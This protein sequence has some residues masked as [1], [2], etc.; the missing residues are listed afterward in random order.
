MSKP[1]D[2]RILKSLREAREYTQDEVAKRAGISKDSLSRIERG[3]QS[4]T[5]QHTIRSLAK[6]FG[7]TPE[8]LTGE[9]NIEE[10]E[11]TSSPRNLL[12]MRIDTSADNALTLV[13]RR[14]GF[15]RDRIVELAPLLFVIAAERSLER[16]RNHVTAVREALN[17]AAAA[18]KTAGCLGEAIASDSDETSAAIAAIDAE[19]ESIANQDII[20]YDMFSEGPFYSDP[21]KENPFTSSL[22]EDATDPDLVVVV[23]IVPDFAIFRV[24]RADAERLADGDESL[25][26]KILGGWV[27]LHEMPSGLWADGA[28]E[29]RLAWLRKQV[30]ESEKQKANMGIHQQGL[31]SDERIKS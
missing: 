6:F 30:A 29:D 15:P 5:R 31:F 21:V 13:S 20:A 12:S 9:K 23:G 22:Q 8:Q 1:I 17:R 27:L 24:C 18:M 25:T 7:V 10:D 14:Y 28:V 11:P 19:E 26:D 3:K 4:G 16:R 2:S